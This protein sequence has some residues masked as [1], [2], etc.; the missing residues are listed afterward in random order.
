M[1]FSVHSTFHCLICS[2]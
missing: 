2:R 1:N